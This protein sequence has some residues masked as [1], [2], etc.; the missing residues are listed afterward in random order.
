MPKLL[1]I[2]NDG[3][4]RFLSERRLMRQL[5]W[6]YDWAHA[7]DEAA[8]RL[9]GTP[10]DALVI[11]QSIPFAAIAPGRPTPEGPPFVWGGAVLLWWLRRR[12]PPPDMPQADLVLEQPFFAELPD[13]ANGNAPAL[14]YSGFQNR[15]VESAQRT[16]H[17]A[18]AVIEIARKPIPFEP[19]Q[20]F[21]NA[22]RASN[23]G[24]KR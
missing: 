5:G 12:T 9:V 1:W 21:L 15:T 22:H 11:D 16:L 7:I 4:T 20:R 19:L 24:T 14:L 13:R 3:P 17:G 18:G 8:E 2:D 23:S 6:E 10:Y